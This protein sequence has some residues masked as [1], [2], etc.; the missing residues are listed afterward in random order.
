LANKCERKSELEK[1]RRR[2]SLLERELAETQKGLNALS[3]NLEKKVED[4]T[5]EIKAQLDQ[6]Q[7]LFNGTGDAIYI[8][9]A[10]G[11]ILEVN[12]QAASQL[13]YSRE[14]L[15]TMQIVDLRPPTD[16]IA[17]PSPGDAQIT[18]ETS[19]V[20]K[21]GSVFP[22]EVNATS[23]NYAER[24]SVLNV[25]RDI[26]ERKKAEEDLQESEKRFRHVVEHSPH[27]IMVHAED[28]EVIVLNDTWKEITGYG[29][30]DIPTMADWIER[31]YDGD[32]SVKGDVDSLFEIEERVD[33]GEYEITTIQ[34]EKRIWDFSSAPL[35]KLPDGRVAVI[36]TASDVTKRKEGEK[37]RK[38]LLY[39]MQE[40]YKELNAL[41]QITR[42]AASK[43]L[44]VREVIEE[45]LD[46]L[47]ESWQYPQITC[48]RISLG[49]KEYTSD[50][51]KKT[52]WR[53]TAR[54]SVQ[55][56]PEGEIEVVYL[57]KK[58]RADEGPFLKEE[59]SLLESLAHILGQLID[60]RRAHKRRNHLNSILKS[61]R[62]VNRLLIKV[63]DRDKLIKGTCSTLYE[64]RG[65]NNV[66]GVLLDK[67]GKPLIWGEAGVGE[68]FNHLL[69]L[70]EEGKLPPH[71]KKTM[72]TPEIVTVVDS[73]A[74]CSDCPLI[75]KCKRWGVI[76]RRLEFE[77]D[78]F[79]IIS[80]SVPKKFVNDE[81]E[82]GLF[83][84]VADDISLGIHDIEVEENLRESENKFR[85]YVESS[86]VGVFVTD[87]NGSYIEVNKAACDMTGYS[88]DELLKMD[89]AGLQAQN[90]TGIDESEFY[91]LKETGE[92]RDEIPFRR[93]DKSK[94]YMVINAVK[95]SED[96]Y[97][98]F[99]LDVTKRKEAEKKLEAT[100]FGVM[101]ALNRTIEAKDEYTG[102][103]ID[104]VQSYSIKMGRALGLPDERLEQLRYAS[105]LHDIGK[106]GVPDSILGKPDKLTRDE[107]REMEKHP[108]IGERIVGQV[109]QLGRAAKIIGQH[110]E[111]YDG[112][113]YPR[114]LEGQEISLEARI[115][116][117][118]DAWDAMR[119][120]RPYRRALS[121]EEAIKELKDNAG[122]QF[123]PDVVQL[124]LDL[125]HK[126][127]KLNSIQ[128]EN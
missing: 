39:D 96:R 87:E 10:D 30:Q 44:T 36:S 27:P 101:R 8:H 85:S 66:W 76:S 93:K 69:E 84:E 20:R 43:E 120:D 48:A 105:I 81:E 72:S 74:S 108:E 34:G 56:Q 86:P 67:E 125:T 97:L 91:K 18:F 5:R 7:R 94:G 68:S 100:T 25:T 53:Q 22:V 13:G 60:R 28:G 3:L 95:L 29:K 92:L 116:A 41:Y 127:D 57:E 99:T 59:R 61:I 26:T 31:A 16:E 11:N 121:R 126:G 88:K 79:G 38:K 115:I 2:I 37:A 89:I 58:P 111:R 122:T 19:H 70:F 47:V 33:E 4:R 112:A 78:I 71:V 21:D 124:F 63:N 119:T 50:N 15:L 128:G 40:R 77:G 12:D 118:A 73:A 1:A 23:I 82:L 52:V 42:L 54:I 117:V 35:G 107:W 49:G 64:T 65:F 113:G 90:A 45:T 51:Y 102:E 103:H 83:N 62:Y 75:E 109:D 106:I 55:G 46:I 9:D 104:R 6:F 32:S 110:Q 24:S 14:Q 114:G 80:A 123:D 17:V 98:G